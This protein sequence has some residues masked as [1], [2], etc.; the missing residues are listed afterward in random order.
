M[1][2]EQYLED[3]AFCPR[4]GQ[5]F[6]ENFQVLIEGPPCWHIECLRCFHEFIINSADLHFTS[7][8]V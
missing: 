3:T 2:I 1:D 7:F 6:R 4:C 8:D 5:G